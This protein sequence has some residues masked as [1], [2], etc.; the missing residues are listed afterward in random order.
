MKV[1]LLEVHKEDADPCPS[2]WPFNVIYWIRSEKRMFRKRLAY[3]TGEPQ[4]ETQRWVVN[5]VAR[6]KA[7]LG[8][9]ECVPGESLWS[10]TSATGDQS[11]LA[12]RVSLFCLTMGLKKK[13]GLLQSRGGGRKNNRKE[14]GQLR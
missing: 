12:G 13:M 4:T 2:A 1:K 6:K 10:V 8:K 11:S 14:K 5:V 3:P 7:S 9:R